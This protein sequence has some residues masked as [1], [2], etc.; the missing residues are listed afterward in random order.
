MSIFSSYIRLKKPCSVDEFANIVRKKVADHTGLEITY[1]TIDAVEAIVEKM[2]IKKLSVEEVMQMGHT[3]E[4]S[5]H[6]TSHIEDMGRDFKSWFYDNI[7]PECVYSYELGRRI[8]LLDVTHEAPQPQ[9]AGTVIMYFSYRYI[10]IG[11][12]T[13]VCILKVLETIL[14]LGGGIVEIEKE[15]GSFRFGEPMPTYE[16][17][18]TN[19][20]DVLYKALRYKGKYHAELSFEEVSA[21]EGFPEG[22]KL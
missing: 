18:P 4:Q 5:R 7:A 17:T 6:I 3:F 15:H 13:D 11:Y 21:L 10:E 8:W 12:Y 1:H 20:D 2:A 16:V 22:F 19:Y 14:E 9:D